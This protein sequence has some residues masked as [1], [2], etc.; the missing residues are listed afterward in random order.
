MIATIRKCRLIAEIS[1]INKARFDKAGCGAGTGRG[2]QQAGKGNSGDGLCAKFR[3]YSQIYVDHRAILR[4]EKLHAR[5]SFTL[6]I[7]T[8]E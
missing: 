3:P 2:Q 5:V 4:T 7:Q 1:G 6:R 8:R